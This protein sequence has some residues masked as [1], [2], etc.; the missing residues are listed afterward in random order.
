VERLGQVVAGPQSQGLHGALHVG[1]AGHEDDLGG[2]AQIQV[3]EQVDALA[4][5]QVEVDEGDVGDPLDD[6]DAGVPERARRLGG[7][8]LPLDQIGEGGE[9]VG[10]VVDG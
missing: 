2:G 3:G 10:V 5:G 9:E 8:T 1:V 7:K 4:V 6:Q